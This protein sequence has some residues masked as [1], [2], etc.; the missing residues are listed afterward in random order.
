MRLM[1][2]EW[3]RPGMRLAKK[4]FNE[5]GLVLL[6]EGVELTQTMLQRLGKYGVSHL[7]IAD[8]RTD[9]IVI[10]DPISEETRRMAIGTIRSHFRRIMMDALPRRA[11]NP[12]YFG[13]AFK[14]VIAAIIDDLSQNPKAMIMLTDISVTDLYL[15]RHS[16]NVCIYST[17]LGIA[18][19]Y[20]R[21]ELTTLGL[22]AMLHDIGK[23]KIPTELLHKPGKLQDDE[24]ETVKKHTE[25]GFQLLKDEP[26]IPLLAAHCALQ[27]HERMD[28]SGY[29]RGIR[30][31]EI[32][33]FAK[34]VALIDSYDAM[35]SHRAYR[36]A[37]LPHQ[38]ME[39]LFSGVGNLYEQE[40][41]ELFRDKVAIYPLGLTVMLSTGE[42]GVVVDIN[43]K[44]PHR[45]IVRVLQDADGQD[46]AVPYEV[47]L[48]K[49]LAIVVAGVGMANTA[50][51]ME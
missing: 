15:Y 51:G 16:L 31:D 27:H 33:E 1:P 43:S 41:V 22:G 10:A 39:M 50:A 37:M 44:C 48:S 2:L 30:G 42:T 12:P 8:P 24:Y 49:H 19:G 46:V 25:F 20:S 45:P 11:V 3:C 40:K 28:G 26:N 21:D 23:T 4:V 36:P 6:A 35:T 13:K 7:Y 5:E 14:E 32:H 34:W 38:A 17:M 47:D 18:Q 9:D 29:P